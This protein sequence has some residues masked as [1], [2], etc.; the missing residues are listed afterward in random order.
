MTNFSYDIQRPDGTHQIISEH[1]PIPVTV[2]GLPNV[3][4]SIVSRLD[5]N[6]ASAQWRDEQIKSALSPLSIDM[7]DLIQSLYY[8]RKL[9]FWG[10][11]GFGVV[12]IGIFVVMLLSLL[13]G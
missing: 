5:R 6:Q 9:L 13:Q 2:A 4:D 8:L 3:S 12:N 10:F 1:N 11:C 7:S